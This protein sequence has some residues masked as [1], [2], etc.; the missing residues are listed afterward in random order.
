MDVF[1]IVCG[2]CSIAGLLVSLFMTSKV[3]AI[4]RIINIGNKDDNSKVI[5]KNSGNTY[6]GPYVGRDSVNGIKNNKQN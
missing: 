3:I 6:H 5:N 2:V 4:L 1:N